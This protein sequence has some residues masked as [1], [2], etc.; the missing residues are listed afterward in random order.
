MPRTLQIA[1][2][3]VRVCTFTVMTEYTCIIYST[4]TYIYIYMYVYVCMYLFA[5]FSRMR[6]T[7]RERE[8]ERERQRDGETERRRDRETETEI[9][10]CAVH[11]WLRV[12]RACGWGPTV[13]GQNPALPIIRNIP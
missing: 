4:H 1:N 9:G 11:V 6:E 2:P 7:E 3:A 5:L 10:C 8:R 12:S 13:D